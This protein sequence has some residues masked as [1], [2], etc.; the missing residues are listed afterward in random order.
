M[1]FYSY[2]PTREATGGIKSRSRKGAF[3]ETWWAKQWVSVIES[4]ELGGRLERG[5]LYA[6]KGQVTR[7]DIAPGIVSASVQGSSSRPYDVAI[8]IGALSVAEWDRV[9]AAV[10][11]RASLIAKLLAGEMP[12]DIGDVFQDAGVALFPKSKRDLTTSCSCPDASNPCKHIAAVYYL[13]GEEFDRDPFLIFELRG[14]KRAELE[15]KLAPSQSVSQLSNPTVDELPAGAAAFW[16][17]STL[18]NA[19]GDLSPQHI[20]GAIVKRLGGVPFWRGDRPLYDVI[21]P[22]YEAAANNALNL[23]AGGVAHSVPSSEHEL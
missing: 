15:A 10:T 8:R 16:I 12:Q 13:I 17:G 9:L 5:K 19:F 4:F 7:I 11:Q 23:F 21:A 20:H 14:L 1:P 2:K 18:P 3:G 22:L 6:R